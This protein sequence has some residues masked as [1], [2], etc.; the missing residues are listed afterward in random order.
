MRI[1][2]RARVADGREYDIMIYGRDGKPGGEGPTQTS[3]ALHSTKN[4]PLRLSQASGS[5][6]R[7]SGACSGAPARQ[8]RSMRSR[9]FTLVEILVVVVIMAVGIRWRS[10]RSA[11][12]GRDSQL[13]EESRRIEGLVGLLHERA[14]LEGRDFGLRIEPA[15]YE[16]VVY[17][18]A[19]RSLADA[20]PGA[21]ISPSRIAQG[22]QFPA[23]ARFPDR[24]HQAHRPE[25]VQRQPPP[26]PQMA[27]AASGEGTPFRLI[28][29]REGT[30]A[31][32][33]VDGDALGKV[34]RESSDQ[35][36]KAHLTPPSRRN[37]RLHAGR[38][39]GR[40]RWWSRW[41]W[42]R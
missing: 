14:L 15:A 7:A 5:L 10:C 25:S 28:L 12:T 39:A 33:S 13:D 29:L 30:P 22:H 32:A 1:Y 2:T 36:G 16:F 3:P 17:E 37:S 35:S 24:R 8:C 40:P 38:G 4:K 19:P 26:G 9:G 23:A 27:I 31:R 11:S 21:R 18:H 41:V 6:S 42:P 20:R 34:A